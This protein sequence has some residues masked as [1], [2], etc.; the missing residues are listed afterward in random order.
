MIYTPGN[1]IAVKPQNL[2]SDPTMGGLWARPRSG[3]AS[4]V[5]SPVI[6]RPEA[7]A[8]AA[9]VR[10]TSSKRRVVL[11]VE[12]NDDV[13]QMYADLLTFFGFR[14]IEATNGLEAL[15]M[16][17]QFRP[18]LVVM[19]MALPLMDGVAA[20]RALKHTSRTARTPVIAV[21][22]FPAEHYR[23]R[24]TAAGCNAFLTEPCSVELL[25][26]ISRLLDR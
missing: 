25:D 4:H 7:T 12:D 14:V 6:G 13:R 10:A 15:S 3:V 24:A 1:A 20:T 5:V 22:G 9:R 16:A 17:S 23:D 8:D 19:D 2:P 18:D 21:T 11:V 26:L